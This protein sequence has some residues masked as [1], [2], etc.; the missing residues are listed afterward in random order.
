M[1]RRR[2]TVRTEPMKIRRFIRYRAAPRSYTLSITNSG[3]ITI[4]PLLRR[5]AY[6]LMALTHV[7][8]PTQ[9]ELGRAA[10]RCRK[11]SL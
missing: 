9:S 1:K 7:Y 5:T 11:S 6:Q 4:G 2:T 3:N 8:S 10:R